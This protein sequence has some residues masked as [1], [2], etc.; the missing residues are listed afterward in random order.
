M[1]VFFA[2]IIFLAF[3][4]SYFIW[5]CILV[6]LLAPMVVLLNSRGKYI[7]ASYWFSFIGFGMFASLNLKM[8]EN[9]NA[10]LLYFPLVMSIVQMHAR[11]EMM[12]HMMIILGIGFFS[13]CIVLYGLREHWMLI[14]NAPEALNNLRTINLFFGLF[15]TLLFVVSISYESI[16][17][18]NLIKGML[19]E[20]EVLLAEVFHR[21][22]NNMNII[23][24][25]LNLKKN[26]SSSPEVQDALEECRNR[27]FSMA[28]VHQKIYSTKN[29]AK[30]NFKE[31]IN[32][33]VNALRESVGSNQA[34]I[35]LECEAIDLE[36]SNAIPSG[37]ILN[38]LIT[39]SFKHATTPK[40]NLRVSIW[41]KQLNKEVMLSYKDNGP[42]LPEQESMNADTLGLVLIKS[43]AEQLDAKFEFGNEKGFTFDLKFSVK[44]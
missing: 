36:L 14:P 12:K 28:L 19:N 16:R 39:N 4:Y 10:F 35:E 27:V 29:I 3:D 40:G 2:L 37:L 20:K 18:E 11:R 31:Y 33:L 5:D 43:L 34:I 13:A 17:Q 22:K 44:K 6:I 41:I 21:V 8:G 26:A 32:E 23:T 30:L 24:S 42:G 25:L 15:T 7:L 9:S 38:E 1:N